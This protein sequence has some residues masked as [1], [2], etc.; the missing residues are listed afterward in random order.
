MARKRYEVEID[1]DAAGYYAQHTFDKLEAAEQF[2]REQ[3]DKADDQTMVVLHDL[4][5][6]TTLE[7]NEIIA[8]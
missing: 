8:D 2:Y 4:A 1:N 5:E 3:C 6:S 7:S